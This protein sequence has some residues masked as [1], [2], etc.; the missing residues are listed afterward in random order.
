MQN[1]VIN[2]LMRVTA[3][4]ETQKGSDRIVSKVR[5]QVDSENRCVQCQRSEIL[6]KKKRVVFTPECH[7]IDHKCSSSPAVEHIASCSAIPLL[8]ATAVSSRK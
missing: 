3:G 8:V 7:R 6:G 1:L 2:F 5:D 4:T